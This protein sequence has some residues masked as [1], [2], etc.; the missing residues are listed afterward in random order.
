MCSC[1]LHICGDFFFLDDAAKTLVV[2]K[3]AKKM[4]VF[5]AV[6]RCLVAPRDLKNMS[7]ELF[8]GAEEAYFI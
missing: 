2:T 8:E 5:V 1:L 4:N 3:T 7:I 6:L